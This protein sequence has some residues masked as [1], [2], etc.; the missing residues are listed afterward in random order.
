MSDNEEATNIRGAS[1][2]QPEEQPQPPASPAI[3]STDLLNALATQFAVMQQAQSEL[4]A[5]VTAIGEQLNG[6]VSGSEAPAARA[7]LAITLASNDDDD[8]DDNDDDNDSTE[9][10]EQILRRSAAPRHDV[11]QLLADTLARLD[12]ASKTRSD[13]EVQKQEALA[14]TKINSAV[15]ALNLKFPLTDVPHYTPYSAFGRALDAIDAVLKTFPNLGS[16]SR[17]RILFAVFGEHRVVRECLT[18]DDDVL[19]HGL[20]QIFGS[21]RAPIVRALKINMLAVKLPEWKPDDTIAHHWRKSAAARND[22]ASFIVSDYVREWFTVIVA[23]EQHRDTTLPDL[24]SVAD[25]T[26]EAVEAFVAKHGQ[27][28][29]SY[30]INNKVKNNSQYP[31]LWSVSDNNNLF[32]D[33][34]TVFAALRG[35]TGT[36]GCVVRAAGSCIAR[37]GARH[38]LDVAIDTQAAVTALD[39]TLVARL[40]LVVRHQRRPLRGPTG[41]AFVSI[42]STSIDVEVGG[43]VVHVVDAHVIEGLGFAV[44]LGARALLTAGLQ[45]RALDGQRWELVVDGGVTVYGGGAVAEVPAPAAASANVRR[46]APLLPTPPP[47]HRRPLPARRAGTARRPAVRRHAS[48]SPSVAAVLAHRL[49]LAALFTMP[50]LDD[51]SL[52]D[53]VYD[54]VDATREAADDASGWRTLVEPATVAPVYDGELDVECGEFDLRI[55]NIPVVGGVLQC[56]DGAIANAVMAALLSQEGGDASTVA[57]VAVGR[58]PGEFPVTGQAAAAHRFASP[59]DEIVAHIGTRDALGLSVD[60]YERLKR[61]AAAR[62]QPMQDAGLLQSKHAP[63]SGSPLPMRHVQHRIQLRPNASMRAVHATPRRFAPAQR[64]ALADAVEQWIGAGIASYVDGAAYVSNAPV[65]VPKTDAN[66]N[67]VGWRVCVDFRMLNQQTERDRH[68][69]PGLYEVLSVAAGGAARS[70]V[71]LASYFHQIPLV[72][73]SR[74]LTTTNVGG[75]RQIAFNRMP[76]GLSNATATAQRQSSKV[77]GNDDQSTCYIDDGVRTHHSCAVDVMLTDLDQL[78]ERSLFYNASWNSSKTFLFHIEIDLL[79]HRVDNNGYRPLPSRL[80]ALRAYPRPTSK[81]AVVRFVQTARFYA[82]H[83]VNFSGIVAPLTDLTA[84]HRP[85]EWSS[86]AERA[87]TTLKQALLSPAVIAP[88]DDQRRVTLYTDASKVVVSYVLQQEDDDGR[89]RII[90]VGGRKLV[91]YERN[92][93]PHESE[94]LAVREATRVYSYYLETDLGF[95]WRTDNVA[96]ANIKTSPIRWRSRAMALFAVQLQGLHFDVEKVAG[97][98]NAAADALSRVDEEEARERSKASREH[99]ITPPTQTAGA[100]RLAAILLDAPMLAPL[101][102][103]AADAPSFVTPAASRDSDTPATHIV[104]VSESEVELMR[105]DGNG[106]VVLVEPPPEPTA[107]TADATTDESATSSSDDSTIKWMSDERKRAQA[108]ELQGVAERVANDY[109]VDQL[110]D[111]SLAPFWAAARA[112]VGGGFEVDEYQRLRHTHVDHPAKSQL[113]RNQLHHNNHQSLIT[114]STIM[115]KFK[116]STRNQTTTMPQQQYHSNTTKRQSN[117]FLKI[118]LLATF[119]LNSDLSIKT[120]I[121]TNNNDI[122]FKQHRILTTTAA[123]SGRFSFALD[124][125]FSFARRCASR[126][127]STR[128]GAGLSMWAASRRC[129]STCCSCRHRRAATSTVC[130]SSTCAPVG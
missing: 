14:T 98:D 79:G 88:Y 11:T 97:R 123:Y 40:G 86:D 104:D 114:L 67:R 115:M 54:T 32:E 113:K 73:E 91:D 3:Q 105:D 64:Q 33:E 108:L 125:N 56:N 18:D 22:A 57:A 13:S 117:R 49:F 7:S 24:P 20:G 34:T 51:S 101:S 82:G 19:H 63:C 50:P 26:V 27:R 29:R 96:C 61:G 58:D 59:V 129:L 30:F 4:A 12:A 69:M 74:P 130:S 47:S 39:A 77:F 107:G 87:F 75:G 8:N 60:E 126:R 46:R 48:S 122:R 28:T 5:Q 94:L 116:Q 100:P 66:G 62:L 110:S 93:W 106:G 6:R 36:P 92:Y 128:W 71:D 103:S 9:A 89:P 17:F 81:P 118:F 10:A 41:Q 84:K 68:A 25:T 31:L 102:R 38:T 2:P 121:K 99:V 119:L 35:D 21:W 1:A 80:D 124:N 72:A 70:V 90:A 78:V 43:G 42:G 95:L 109:R 120:I 76:F 23:D 52:T 45:L 83:I 127:R 65:V 112:S 55:S 53:L 15:K 16:K 44:L 111:M 37:D 85:F